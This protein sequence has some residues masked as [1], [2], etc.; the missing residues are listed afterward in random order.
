MERTIFGD[1]SGNDLNTIAAIEFGDIGVVK[2][3]NLACWEHAQPLLK[4]HAYSQHEDIHING[5]PP[6]GDVAAEGIIYT[7]LELKAIVTNRSL[8]DVV[9]H[10]SR[11]DLLE[12]R[13]DTKQ[14]HLVVS[15]K[16]K[17]EHA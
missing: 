5:W 9:S 3:G 1:G 15:T 4:Y 17:H 10:Y 2:V 11:P 7:E 14:K 12:L 13:V 6:I 8:L 16:D